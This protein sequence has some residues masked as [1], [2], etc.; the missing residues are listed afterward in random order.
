MGKR[1]VETVKFCVQ[2]DCNAKTLSLDDQTKKMIATN[3]Y[4]YESVPVLRRFKIDS[5]R[6]ILKEAVDCKYKIS[7]YKGCQLYLESVI[8]FIMMVSLLLKANIWSVVYLIF[9]IKYARTRQRT[10]LMIRICI[11]IS[12]SLF[13]QYVLFLLNLTANSSTQAF[14][15]I[16]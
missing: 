6:Q 5:L 8:I 11:Y 2:L 16:G 10:N 15:S 7:Y 9:I 3:D 4:D 13:A 12:A 1:I 14:P